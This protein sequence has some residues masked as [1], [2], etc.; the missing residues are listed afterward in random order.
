MTGITFVSCILNKDQEQGS[1]D[2]PEWCP[3]IN[4]FMDY[5][6]DSNGL[7]EGELVKH[8]CFS[9]AAV[10]L[11][12]QDTNTLTTGTN[13]TTGT[14]G[15]TGTKQTVF[16][17][18][19]PNEKKHQLII[20]LANV[21][22]IDEESESYGPFKVMCRFNEQNSMAFITEMTVMI[23]PQQFQKQMNQWGTCNKETILIQLL[24]NVHRTSMTDRNNI[25]GVYLHKNLL[26]HMLSKRWCQHPEWNEKD[27]KLTPHQETLV[28]KILEWEVEMRSRLIDLTMFR[29][30]LTHT[31]FWYDPRFQ[32]LTASQTMNWRPTQVGFLN[33]P[34]GTG[35]R[36]SLLNAITRDMFRREQSNAQEKLLWSWQPWTEEC[37]YTSH[38]T[39]IVCPLFKVPYWQEQLQ[40]SL[41]KTSLIIRVIATPKDGRKFSVKQLIRSDIVIV[42]PEYL[43]SN[44]YS[45]D[46]DVQ[47]SS[48]MSESVTP[49]F[50]KRNVMAYTRAIKQQQL[51][52]ENHRVSLSSLT[53]SRIVFDVPDTMQMTTLLNI[54]SIVPWCTPIIWIVSGVPEIETLTDT[55]KFVMN[56]LSVYPFGNLKKIQTLNN[57][58]DTYIVSRIDNVMHLELTEQ[59]R[60]QSQRWNYLPI[61]QQ[62]FAIIH[63]DLLHFST[64]AANQK[65]VLCQ[66]TEDV[67]NQWQS[68]QTTSNTFFTQAVIE[69]QQEVCCIC[70]ELSCDSII[71]CGHCFCWACLNMSLKQKDV[72]PLCKIPNVTVYHFSKPTNGTK[73]DTLINNIQAWKQQ[74]YDIFIYVDNQV[75]QTFMETILV[76]NGLEK[77]L[78][79]YLCWD[80]ITTKHWTPN[81]L[82]KPLMKLVFLHSNFTYLNVQQIV[83]K[84][85]HP[86]SNVSQVEV[87]WLLGKGTFE[88][89]LHHRERLGHTGWTKG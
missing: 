60:V 16:I 70:C 22:E 41:T 23:R 82:P 20:D 47:F 59:E 72:C 15:T 78:V 84:F 52:F 14:T 74:Q 31:N 57:V 46:I 32:V 33:D 28:Q 2:S 43:V 73:I 38:C 67:V 18:L 54:A 11:K 37:F 86:G 5:E 17:P 71:E 48:V 66:D 12:R 36:V 81:P 4:G 50:F 83:S 53:W 8:Y 21:S 39:L 13:G 6:N 24:K 61:D 26:K 58:L 63:P 79:N 35:K 25:P 49:T 40:K 76:K 55:Q 65:I 56:M 45:D 68:R 62:S 89:N 29:V 87:V 19:S 85:R 64:D 3:L 75:V 7:F 69:C 88:P 30:K 42:T 1:T 51:E 44:G 77:G 27:C 80:D 9:G 34:F 10:R